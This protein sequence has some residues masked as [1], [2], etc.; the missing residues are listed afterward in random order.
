MGST[1]SSEWISAEGALGP[2]D[3]A[4]QPSVGGRLSHEGRVGELNLA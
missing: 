3:G 1:L 4:P 2:E